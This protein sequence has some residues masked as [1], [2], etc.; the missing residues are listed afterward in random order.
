MSK[1]V[2][3]N[4]RPTEPPRP[5][6]YHAQQYLLGLEHGFRCIEWKL[7][8]TT[9]GCTC[10]LS[11]AQL[12]VGLTREAVTAAADQRGMLPFWEPVPHPW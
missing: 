2:I 10:G 9:G 4:V 3:P 11:A 6:L 12:D 5:P 1:R 7:A 8:G